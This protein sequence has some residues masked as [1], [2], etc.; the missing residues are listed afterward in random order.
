ML[1]KTVPFGFVL[2][3]SSSFIAARVG[4]RHLS[5]LLFVAIRMAACSVVLVLLMLALRRSWRPLRGVWLHLAFAGVLLNGVL[6]MT[7]H[8]AMVRIGAAPIAL[9]QTLNP[10]LTALLAWPV[11]G[12]RLRAQQWLGLALG[13]FGVVLVVGLAAA[14]SHAELNGLLLAAA[15]VVGLCGGTLYYRRFC[16]TAPMLEGTTVQFVACTVVCGLSTWLFETPHA[17]W[18]PGAVTAVAWNAG[19]VS[20]GGMVL[21]FVMLK[22]GSAARA[23]ANFYLVPGTA[24]LLAWVLLGETLSQLAVLGLVVSS[25][26]CWLVNWRPAP[27]LRSSSATTSPSSSSPR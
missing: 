11:L 25:I 27:A 7:A 3:W 15:G 17:D 4:L 16:L 9:V 14:R 21:Y 12:E 10:L 13:A 8:V 2:L 20:L 24:G 22:R 6:L 19:G 18:T 1:D 5:P 26:G 23:T